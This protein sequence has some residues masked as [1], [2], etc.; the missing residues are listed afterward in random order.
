MATERPGMETQ[1]IALDGDDRDGSVPY[2]RVVITVEPLDGGP[3]TRVTVRRASGIALDMDYQDPGETTHGL[4]LST[5][6]SRLRV[7]LTP[8]PE[9]GDP[10]VIEE[11]V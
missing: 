9:P 5:P 1:S 4:A 7:S 8:V 11:V 2:Y 6:P 3:T 10:A